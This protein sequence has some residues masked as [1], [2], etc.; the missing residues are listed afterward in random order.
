MSWSLLYFS[1]DAR[2]KALERYRVEFRKGEFRNREDDGSRLS[3]CQH[4]K[5]TPLGRKTGLRR[6][7]AT[8]RGARRASVS[9]EAARTR[10]ERG[11]RA[12]GRAR[13]RGDV[14]R[15]RESREFRK[16]D[17]SR[18]KGCRRRGGIA[19]TVVVLAGDVTHVG[20]QRVGEDERKQAR[21]ARG[22]SKVERRAVR[23]VPR[24]SMRAFHVA[25][26]ADTSAESPEIGSAFRRPPDVNF[27]WLLSGTHFSSSFSERANR[28]P[29]PRPDVGGRLRRG[30]GERRRRRRA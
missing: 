17:I 11:A 26:F 21:G 15:A 10:Y 12:D 27:F 3:P 6:A 7:S 2:T 25:L 29:R 22:R 19:R 20:C 30:G 1:A 8:S 28:P 4:E 23:R 24:M 13:G 9:G 18:E 5:R 14:A 16:G